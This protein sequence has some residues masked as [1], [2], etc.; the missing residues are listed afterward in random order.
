MPFLPNIQHLILGK[1]ELSE[2]IEDFSR[3]LPLLGA[4]DG[5]KIIAGVGN[6]F[7]IKEV[8]REIAGDKI[9]LIFADELMG[10][11]GQY[12]NSDLINQLLNIS[13]VLVS[14]AGGAR[15]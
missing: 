2:V 10:V 7:P 6:N 3:N 15:H 12:L 9:N 8:L 4:V 11:P 14:K 1:A 13:N 5:A